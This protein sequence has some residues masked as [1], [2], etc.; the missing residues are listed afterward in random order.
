M[1][2]IPKYI[3]RRMF[4]KDCIKKVEGGIE[5]VFINI[6][7]PMK[8]EDL[9]DDFFDHYDVIIDGKS[10]PKELKEKAKITLNDKEYTKDNVKEL[11]GQTVPVGGQI[12]VYAPVD[13]AEIGIDPDVEHDI[14]LKITITEN[15][16]SYKIKRMLAK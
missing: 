4:P 11:E 9:P 13:I 1:S 15:V 7:A 3:L 10:V 6:I 8:I 14:E 2:Y 5:V 12:K 16:V